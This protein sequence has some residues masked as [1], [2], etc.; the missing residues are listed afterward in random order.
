MAWYWKIILEMLGLMFLGYL[1]YLYHKSKIHTYIQ[2]ERINEVEELLKLSSDAL[3]IGLP[4]EQSQVVHKLLA[5]LNQVQGQGKLGISSDL[6]K[7]IKYKLPDELSLKKRILSLK[8]EIFEE[9][10]NTKIT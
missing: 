9:L 7:E 10:E 1:Y 5:I 6:F 4:F 2:K 8:E 3:E